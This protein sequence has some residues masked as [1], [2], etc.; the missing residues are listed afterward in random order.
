M[1]ASFVVVGD[2]ACWGDDDVA[3]GD[4][5]NLSVNHISK[6][7]LQHYD[8]YS[9]FSLLLQDTS[10]LTSLTIAFKWMQK[11]INAEVQVLE[12]SCFNI[13]FRLVPS[14]SCSG[15]SF[16]LEEWWGGIGLNI[17]YNDNCQGITDEISESM[18]CESVQLVERTAARMRFSSSARLIWLI[19]W[20]FC[21]HAFLNFY[22][23]L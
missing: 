2:A 1:F 3:G 6:C 9:P 13:Y 16:D 20:F 15:M 19:T 14:V 17:S 5:A 18:R 11:K 12:F 8:D 23:W 22:H 7:L 4:L 10:S 21:W